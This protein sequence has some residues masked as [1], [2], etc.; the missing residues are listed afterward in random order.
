MSGI[1]CFQRRNVVVVVVVRRNLTV[2]AITQ[3]NINILFSCLVEWKISP[4]GGTLSSVVKIWFP[5][6]PPQADFCHKFH[7]FGQIFETDSDNCAKSKSKIRWYNFHNAT[8]GHFSSRKT[9]IWPYLQNKNSPRRQI[10]INRSV[11]TS[12]EFWLVQKVDTIFKMAT[13][14]H[15][16][17]HILGPIFRTESHRGT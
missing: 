15:H 9:H 13:T 8:T 10:N 6:W 11:L 16:K 1:L 12:Y 17:I 5:I 3:T 4:Q 7:I 2:S 14:G